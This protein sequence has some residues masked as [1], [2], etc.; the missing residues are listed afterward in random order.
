VIMRLRAAKDA[1]ESAKVKAACAQI[2]EVYEELWANLKVGESEAE[3]NSR[4]AYSLAR[5]GG[6]NPGPHILFGEHAGDSH[7]SPG[8]RT[9]QEGDVIV[10]DISAQ[11]DGYWGDMTRCGSAGTPSDWTA[12][13]WKVVKEAYDDA[14]AATRVGNTARDVDA[15]QRAIIEAHPEIGAC[16]HGAGHAIGTEIHEPPFLIA[17]SD[18]PL[19]EGMIFTVEPGIYNSERGGLRLEDDILVAPDG[20]VNLSEHTLELRIVGG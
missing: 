12:S 9:L 19:V 1:E 5:R 8:E 14:V 4:I 13:A 3:V 6:G 2:I 20:P 11:F 18:T 10:A 7:G 15:A 17:S 16:L